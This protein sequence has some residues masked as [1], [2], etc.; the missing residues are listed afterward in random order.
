MR[1]AFLRSVIFSFCKS[2]VV[3]A[4]VAPFVYKYVI[5]RCCT[6]TSKY[7]AGAEEP[8]KDKENKDPDDR[9]HVLLAFA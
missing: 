7:L 1:P 4:P 6:G 2:G 8:T 9:L 3:C 5:G